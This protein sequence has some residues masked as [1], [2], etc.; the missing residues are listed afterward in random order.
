MVRDFILSVH[1][2]RFAGDSHLNRRI[3]KLSSLG[4]VKNNLKDRMIWSP[5]F[6]VMSLD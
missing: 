2:P 6:E 1:Y 4:K 3:G 5:L